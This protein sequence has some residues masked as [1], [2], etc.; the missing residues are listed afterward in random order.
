VIFFGY[1]SVDKPA[2]EFEFID[3]NKSEGTFKDLTV[4]YGKD[5]NKFYI[6]PMVY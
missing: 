2:E 3:L 4:K 1:T 6:E 5:V